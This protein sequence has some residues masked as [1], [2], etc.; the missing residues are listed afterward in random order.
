MPLA[1]PMWKSVQM[2]IKVHFEFSLNYFGLLWRELVEVWQKPYQNSEVH[3]HTGLDVYKFTYKKGKYILTQA[4]LLLAAKVWSFVAYL[5]KK[6]YRTVSWCWSPS[7]SDATACIWFHSIKTLICSQIQQY[8]AIKYDIS[9][10][11]PIS[12]HRLNMVR[13]KVRKYK[14]KTCHKK[15]IF[16]GSGARP[17]RD[18][19]PL[20]PRRG[21]E[22]N[23]Q[24]W[25]TARFHTQGKTEFRFAIS[26]LMSLTDLEQTHTYCHTRNRKSKAKWFTGD[27]RSAPSQV[28]CSQAASCWFLPLCGKKSELS[29]LLVL[30]IIL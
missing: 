2:S 14:I 19:D 9:P 20:P 16:P 15:N 10:L 30:C 28:F 7:T 22:A 13:K 5:F 27:D 21:G 29:G 17:G 25:H 3:N 26:Y 18:P 6:Q 11:S 4:C 8:K 12:R 24:T 1:A 23:S